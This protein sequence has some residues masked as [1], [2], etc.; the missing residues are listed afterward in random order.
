MF[1]ESGI[2]W[3]PFMIAR[4]DNEWML[5]PSEAPLLEKKPSEY[6]RDFYFSTQPIEVL[7]NASHMQAIFEMCNGENRFVY[8]SDYPHQDFDL[9]STI[10][11]LGFLGED[12]RRKILGGNAL[13]LFG[14]DPVLLHERE[15][16]PE[17]RS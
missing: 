4:L 9:P 2:A 8:A 12:A 10:W 6:I 7:D 16:R 5:R 15:G 13:E 11:D 1:M 3:I 17:A 14:L